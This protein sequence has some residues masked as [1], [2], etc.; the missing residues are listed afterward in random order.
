MELAH[1]NSLRLLKL[2]NTLLDF[3][4]IE[5]GRIQASYEPTDLAVLTAEL[6]SVFRSAI[7]RAGMR[8]VVDCPS[9]PEM[10]YV[11]REMWEK[12][13]LNLLSNAF[14]FTFE[15]E[16]AVSV[17]GIDSAVQLSV[18]DTGTGIPAHEIPRL[19]ERFHR[20]TGAR[21]RSYEGSGIGLAL[22]QE[23]VKLHGGKVRVE[24]ELDHG[25]SFIVTI[26]VGKDH[27]PA[28]R[29]GGARTLA[30][31][32]VAGEAY[33]EEALRWL[34]ERQVDA[35]DVQAAT[36]SSSLSP[37]RQ[38]LPDS[39]AQHQELPRILLADDN[40][41]MR[42]YVQRL[43]QPQYQV[44]AVAN[45]ELALKSARERRPDLILADVMMPVMDGFELLRTL[46]ADEDL[47]SVP[48]IFLSAR[49]GEESRVEGLD[50]GAD[51]YLVKPFSAR[52]LLARVGSHLAVA[53]IRGDAAEVERK[54][55]LDADMLAAIVASSDDAIISKN[56][57]GVITTWNQGAERIFGY[58]AEEAVGRHITLIIPPERQSEEVEILARLRRGERVDHFQTVRRSKDGKRLDIS[59][60]ISPLRDSGG[61][62]IGA[63]KVARDIS[64]QKRAEEASRESEEKYRKLSESLDAEVRARTSELEERNREVLRQSEQVRGLSWRLL[65]TQDDERRHIA[66]ELHDS[67]GS[68]ANGAGNGSGAARAKGWT[69]CARTG[70][71]CG[72]DS[73]D[74]A[75]AA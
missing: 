47:K 69:Q 7:E 49:A 44:M 52:E 39:A 50:A 54:L 16:I 42:E 21:G 40:A 37:F 26:P 11:D 73:G 19:F 71:R 66:R 51:D 45:G 55:R 43:L 29:I 2:V 38:N 12:V 33:L 48:V 56:L 41:D 17:R 5:A 35:E 14:K 15:G 46:R 20:V 60:T 27:L 22:V 67:A 57:D 1:R 61:R 53:R 62:V 75:A 72:N 34:P 23:L 10:T 70:N 74:S 13:V 24:S 4:R 31:T 9:L 58:T 6:A 63:S 3:S 25:S 36:L 18:R 28:E 8:L 64:T 30:S 32:V 68:N 59:A 65:R